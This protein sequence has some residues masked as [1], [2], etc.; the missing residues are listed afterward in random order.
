MA[1]FA[2]RTHSRRASEITD[3]LEA[4]VAGKAREIAIARGW[5]WRP[6]SFT[7]RARRKA[8]GPNG[9]IAS[10]KHR[11]NNQR[12]FPMEKRRPVSDKADAPVFTPFHDWLRWT[13]EKI[14]EIRHYWKDRSRILA[15]VACV[16]EP[17]TLE[18][19]A[20][21]FGLSGI[22]L[23]ALVLG[24]IFGAVKA[25]YEFP[26]LPIDREIES[27]RDLTTK[28]E[29]FA[30][31]QGKP[32]ET[33]PAWAKDLSDEQVHAQADALAN[34]QR[35][36]LKKNNRS[37]VEAADLS[38]TNERLL[39]LDQISVNRK[40]TGV[41][42]SRSTLQTSLTQH[43]SDLL[44]VK[45][46]DEA[47]ESWSELIAAVALMLNAYVFAWWIRRTHTHVKFRNSGANAYLYVLGATFLLPSLAINFLNVTTD[48]SERYQWDKF[49]LVRPLLIFSVAVWFVLAF[50]RASRLI[51]TAVGVQN[52]TP[53]QRWSFF[54]RMLLSQA[55]VG[56]LV[57][58]VVAVAATPVLLTIW[59]LHK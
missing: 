47:R 42:E 37:H 16:R 43:Q 25:V 52:D 53:R 49:L 32:Q 15:N 5:R 10:N 14:I 27:K 17:K 7:I 34:R 46:F 8:Q 55:A 58:I 3:I 21:A 31:L 11:Y 20:F 19:G 1:C 18:M 12:D 6:L 33:E 9:Q 44:A 57:Q 50:W 51:S 36:L 24:L 22:V 59:K 45:K 39:A 13:F 4:V 56:I 26:P 29:V 54:G 23:P 28:L 35:D 2:C 40:L 48:L 38:A 30:Q 41:S